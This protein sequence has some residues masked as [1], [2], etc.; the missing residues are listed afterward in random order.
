MLQETIVSGEKLID[1]VG[2][3]WC[4]SELMTLDAIGK[5]KGLAVVWDPRMVVFCD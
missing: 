5:S 4:G 3:C 1:I 2:K